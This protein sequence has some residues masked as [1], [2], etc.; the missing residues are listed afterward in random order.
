MHRATSETHQLDKEQV[1]RGMT[2]TWAQAQRIVAMRIN[3][4][5]DSMLKC[6]LRALEM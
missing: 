6:V 1:S 3:N 4:L 2:Y 5:I